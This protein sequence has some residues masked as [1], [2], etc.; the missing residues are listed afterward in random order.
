MKLTEVLDDKRTILALWVSYLLILWILFQS[1]SVTPVFV[2]IILYSVSFITVLISFYMFFLAFFAFLNR[3]DD[4]Y[5]FM[6]YGFPILIS[7]KVLFIIFIPL[8]NPEELTQPNT[9]TIQLIDQIFGYF[10]GYTLFFRL[11]Y[12]HKSDQK[13]KKYKLY[14]RKKAV[15]LFIGIFSLLASFSFYSSFINNIELFHN[16]SAL[17]SAVLFICTLYKY[18]RTSY[19]KRNIFEFT[20]FLVAIG[21]VAS[22]LIMFFVFYNNSYEYL[23]LRIIVEGSTFVVVLI[24]FVYL[25]FLINQAAKLDKKNIL[26]NNIK[27]SLS[28]ERLERALTLTADKEIRISTI[29][30]NVTDALITIDSDFNIESFNHSAEQMFGFKRREIVGKSA[31]IIVPDDYLK[32]TKEVYEKAYSNDIVLEVSK[33]RETYRKRK[34][35]SVFPALITNREIKLK[36]DRLFVAIVRDITEERAQ[37]EEMQLVHKNLIIAK[38]DAETANKMK[39]Q[40]LAN[41]THE[42]RTPMNSILGFSKLIS[43]HVGDNEKIEEYSTVIHSNG[44]RLLALINSILD[45]SSVESGQSKLHFSTFNVKELAKVVDVLVPLKKEKNISLTFRVN[46]Q[47]P[48]M[49]RTDEEKVF[50]ILINLAGNAIKYTEAGEVSIHLFPYEN[51]QILFKVQDTGQGISEEHME[52]IFDDFYQIDGESQKLKGSG[53]GLSISKQL[54]EMLGGDIWVESELGKGTTFNFTIDNEFAENNLEAELDESIDIEKIEKIAQKSNKQ[55]KEELD[56]INFGSVFARYE[57]E[58]ILFLA[59]DSIRPMVLDVMG[60]LPIVYFSDEDS[61]LKRDSSEYSIAFIF[62]ECPYKRLLPF[63]KFKGIV[64]IC[65]NSL[66]LKPE[67]LLTEGFSDVAAYPFNND[68][69]DK[70]LIKYSENYTEDAVFEDTFDEFLFTALKEIMGIQFFRKSDILRELNELIANSPKKYHKS[71]KLLIKDVDQHN[72]EQFI[73][74]ANEMISK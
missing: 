66:E 38:D 49:I 39:T 70:V 52:H 63:L 3:D 4:K 15:L 57:Q 1:I 41:I 55:I 25:T 51:N 17:I 61:I 16:S 60:M 36:N 69:I 64:S 59:P 31:S 32:E 13:E 53:L 40:L 50:Q 58:P 11:Y 44:R 42:L 19:W 6:I 33:P 20:F 24:S 47:I 35:G 29:I 2:I 10:I 68:E 67:L 71:L 7:L 18:I 22:E 73:K 14:N 72:K 45:L 48:K 9:T 28:K 26:V 46:K 56:I 43:K 8:E 65:L 5:T 23:M 30:D 34:D 27:L 74:R 21:V 54:A 37:K 62:G 12:W